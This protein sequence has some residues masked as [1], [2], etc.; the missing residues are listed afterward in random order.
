[1]NITRQIRQEPV[2]LNSALKKVG[3][4]ILSGIGIGIGFY[5]IK[6]VGLK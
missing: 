4:A 3:I 2:T 5:L 1:M 6:K